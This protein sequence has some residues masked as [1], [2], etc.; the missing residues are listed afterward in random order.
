MMG[1]GGATVRDGGDVVAGDA[2]YPTSCAD[3]GPEP[4]IPAACA[5]VNATKVSTN[6]TLSDEAALD[7][8]AIQ[9]AIDACPAGQSV[10]LA[11]SGANNALLS[12]PINLKSGVTLWI[13]AGVTLFASRNP[14]DFDPKPGQCAQSGGG[15]G[16]QALINASKVAHAAVMGGGAIDGRGGEV[17]VGDTMTW[18]ELE[19]AYAGKLS[20]PRLVQVSGS[21]D[22]TLYKVSLHNS[23]K[24]HVV[25]DDTNGF[26]VWG[27]TIKTPPTS[28]N[29]D[30]VDPSG[31][32]NGVIAYTKISTGDDNVALKGSG[33]L[34]DNI[35]VAHNHFGAGHGMSIGS[36]T[37]GGV[38]NVKVCDLALD[39]TQNGLRIKS[40]SSR[41]GLVQGVTYTDVC[42]RKVNSP[43]VF[44]PFYS[45]ATGTQIPDFQ[46]ISLHNVHVLGGGSSTIQGYD[47]ARP[48]KISF[49]NVVVDDQSATYD[50]SNAQVAL[51]P[52]RVSFTPSGSNVKVTDNVTRTDPPKACDAVWVTF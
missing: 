15:G 46:D 3:I 48:L 36:E 22:F 17:V 31:S 11:V 18:W 42:M 13:D 30:G 4:T 35:I 21:Q 26:V 51:G 40:D 34:M 12:G 38:Q 41:G 24:F 1:G 28:P 8:K 27:I 20:A 14:R 5:T 23:G 2:G 43:F 44:D 32:T 39:G 29:T 9:A 16:C 45:G 7:T 47:A 33:P 6:G 10:K 19:K 49:D 25:I 52:G 37:Y 50:A